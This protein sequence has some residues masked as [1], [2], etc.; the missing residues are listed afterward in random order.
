M[1]SGIFDSTFG[2]SIS[3]FVAAVTFVLYSVYP[4]IVGKYKALEKD[5]S[6]GM[7]DLQTQILYISSF[8]TLFFLLLFFFTLFIIGN[9]IMIFLKTYE[10]WLRFMILSIGFLLHFSLYKLVANIRQRKRN[11][12]TRKNSMFTAFVFKVNYYEFIAFILFLALSLTVVID[13]KNSLGPFVNFR[14][15]VL[16]LILI[17]ISILQ[18]LSYS[19]TY[20]DYVSGFDEE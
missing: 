6:S 9:D 3:Y 12:F 4:F 7:D 13:N 15:S 19:W 18:P 14:T 10:F 2:G 11:L 1:I 16:V 5:A 17:P 20:K 8:Q